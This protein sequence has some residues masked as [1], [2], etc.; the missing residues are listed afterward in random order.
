MIY[1]CRDACS[2]AA[3]MMIIS[4]RRL[5]YFDFRC[6]RGN[7]NQQRSETLFA[8]TIQVPRVKFMCSLVIPPYRQVE[9]LASL[10]LSLR[11][12]WNFLLI[13]LHITLVLFLLFSNTTLDSKI[14]LLQRPLYCPCSQGSRATWWVGLQSSNLH[15]MESMWS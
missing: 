9:C 10:R 12:H 8:S 11:Y 7:I 2:T 14:R 6:R 3:R 4:W 5:Q 13:T 1:R 15:T